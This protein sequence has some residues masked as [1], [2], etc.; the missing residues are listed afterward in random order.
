[1]A[2]QTTREKLD[3]AV[4]KLVQLSGD[5]SSK[6]ELLAETKPELVKAKTLR[7]QIERLEERIRK[8]EFKIQKLELDLKKEQLAA[9][10]AEIETDEV[11]VM[12]VAFSTEDRKTLDAIVAKAHTVLSLGATKLILTKEVKAA[13]DFLRHLVASNPH[14]WTFNKDPLKRYKFVRIGRLTIVLQDSPAYD[15]SFEFLVDWIGPQEAK[16]F[17]KVDTTALVKAIL[18]GEVKDC[19]GKNLNEEDWRKKRTRSVGSPKVKI[20]EEDPL[21]RAKVLVLNPELLGLTLDELEV[22][23]D[24]TGSEINPLKAH[25]LSRVAEIRGFSGD[26][27]QAI[28]GIGSKRAE[29]LIDAVSQLSENVG[30][31][32]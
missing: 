30:D 20:K 8:E 7:D 14:G 2:S 12:D 28:P 29:K 15:I 16:K 22:T 1:M 32:Q 6:Q 17:A 26:Q 27:L 3:A 11:A 31:V 9:L 4:A 25:G 23:T 13:E 5:L 24:L 19:D 10:Q 21:G 18:A